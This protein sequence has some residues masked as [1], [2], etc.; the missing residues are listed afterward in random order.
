ML[1]HL[2]KIDTTSKKTIVYESPWYGG[3]QISVALLV[4]DLEFWWRHSLKINKCRHFETNQ[5][6]RKLPRQIYIKLFEVSFKQFN[7]KKNATEFYNHYFKD[8]SSML[9]ALH[10]GHLYCGAWVRISSRQKFASSFTSAMSLTVNERK[11]K[12]RFDSM[13]RA[14]NVPSKDLI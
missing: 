1:H 5:K 4:V 8:L 12:M 14:E 13:W 2:R 11:E 6:I 7:W 10:L 9:I 3:K